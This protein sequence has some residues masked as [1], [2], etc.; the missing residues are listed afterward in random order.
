MAPHGSKWLRMA[1][2]GSK[3]FEMAP[4]GFKWLQMA[5]RLQMA[6]NGTLWLQMAQHCSK[7]LQS[8]QL[9]PIKEQLLVFRALWVGQRVH[10]STSHAWTIHDSAHWAESV[11]NSE[12]FSQYTF[13]NIHWGSLENVWTNWWTFGCGLDFN[14]QRPRAG[15]NWEAF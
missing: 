9:A 5:Q 3:W 13:I 15:A 2:N 12:R 7:W 1:W 6:H 4:Y 8:F 11:K 14:P 10:Q